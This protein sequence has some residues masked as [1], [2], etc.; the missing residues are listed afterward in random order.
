MQEPCKT[1]PTPQSPNDGARAS[2]TGAV[3]CAS[4]KEMPQPLIIT[5]L[6]VPPT[7]SEQCKLA[8]FLVHLDKQ[9]E[10]AQLLIE[11]LRRIKSAFLDEMFV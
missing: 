1:R 10:I 2:A 6:L 9:I 11:L 7:L 5:W 8:S 3:P 4:P